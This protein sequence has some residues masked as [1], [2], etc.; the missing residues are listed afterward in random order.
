VDFHSQFGTHSTYQAGL[1]YFIPVL[2]TKLKA[3]YGT[4]F[5]A[6]SLYQLYDPSFGNLSLQ[7]ENSTGFD[8]GFEQPLW[9]DFVRVGATYFHQDYNS[10]IDF[11]STGF[12]TGQYFNVGQAQSDG[13]EAFADLKGVRNLKMRLDYTSTHAWDAATGLPLIQ[14]PQD[15]LSLETYYRQNA[16]EWGISF[17][18]V[19]PRPDLNFST[20][21]ATR[22]TMDS[23]RLVNLR[24]AW[25]I[26]PRV[27][28]FARVDNLLNQTYEET[29]GYGTPGL[30]A[31]LGVKLSYQ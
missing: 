23:Y 20:Y 6:P 27:K 28:L 7:P 4:G 5:L 3:T 1:A 25:Q 24:A 31:Y 14:G 16:V 11:V 17:V 13:V 26:D 18:V 29:W 19:G 30:S 12:F 10:L 2:E 8:A 15:K 22:V 9:D 21:P